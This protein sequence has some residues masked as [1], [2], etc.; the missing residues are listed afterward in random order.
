M[1]QLY[2]SL[3]ASFFCVVFIGEIRVFLRERNFRPQ[4]LRLI[5]S[6]V[7][8]YKVLQVGV[9]LHI[10][11]FLGAGWSSPVARQAHNLKVVGSNPTPATNLSVGKTMK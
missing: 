5:K 7:E 3:D 6:T 8:A 4:I 11:P 9:G 10:C 1:A 2:Q